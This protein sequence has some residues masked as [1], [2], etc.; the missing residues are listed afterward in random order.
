MFTAFEAELDNEAPRRLA[1]SIVAA[2]AVL[3]ALAFG[4]MVISGRVTPEKEA[5]KVVDVSFRPPPPPPEPAKIE[6]APP[7]PPPKVA[8]VVQAPTPTPV[9]ALEAPAPQAAAMVAP[10]EMPTNAAPEVPV[11]QAVAARN[12]AVG[13]T[14]D[15][16]GT[17]VG[18]AAAEDESPAPVAA[19]AGGGPI[20]LPED[21][22]PPEP[23]EGNAMPEYPE[24]ERTVGHESVVILKIVIEADGR[25]GRIIVMKGDEPFLAAALNAVRSWHYEP[26]KLDGQTIATFKIV[27]IPFR[28]KT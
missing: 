26:A 3:G 8:K 4:A 17:A 18:G 27:K 12:V 14:G 5:E 6:N 2:M 23:D 19:A 11:D 22:D 1:I 7:P 16:T 10:K 25:V 15:G 21:A 24:A 28:L 20:N 9:A 13:G